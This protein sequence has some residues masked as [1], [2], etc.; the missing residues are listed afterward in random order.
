[1][2]ARNTFVVAAALVR[3]ARGCSSRDRHFQYQRRNHGHGDRDG[4][5][6]RQPALVALSRRDRRRRQGRGVAL[7]DALGDDAAPLGLVARDVQARRARHDHGLAGSQRPELVLPRDDRVCGRQLGRPLRAAFHARL[8]R[9][10]PPSAGALPSRRAEPLGRLGARAARDDGPARPRRRARSALAS[11]EIRAGREHGGERAPVPHARRRAHAGRP[12][13]RPMRSRRT[14]RSTTRACAAR[15]RAS[16][17]TGPTTAP[18]IA[19]R[20]RPTR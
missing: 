10:P 16:S 6:L 20:K 13:R 4:R 3:G 5:R 2:T 14:T 18:S 19:S 12:E 1:M 8:R 11:A 15:R 17:S 9:A 7:R